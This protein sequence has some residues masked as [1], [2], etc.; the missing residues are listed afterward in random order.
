MSG[1][2]VIMPWGAGL[3]SARGLSGCGGLSGATEA[4]V[5]LRDTSI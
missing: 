3:M 1:W 2:K 5:T 4:Q